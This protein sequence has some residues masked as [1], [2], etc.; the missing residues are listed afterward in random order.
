[1]LAVLLLKPVILQV[2]LLFP[3]SRKSF[4]KKQMTLSG[5]LTVRH[6]ACTK[7]SRPSAS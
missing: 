4:Q 3:R 5:M 7:K 6:D 2:C 1:M